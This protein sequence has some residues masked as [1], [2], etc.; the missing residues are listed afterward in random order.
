MS[1]VPQ[2]LS[3]EELLDREM[4]V[5]FDQESLEFALEAI[6]SAFNQSLPAG[7]T[8]PPARIIGGD[9]ELMGITQNQQVRDFSKANLPLRTVLTDL[10]VGANPDKSSSG[11]S[12]PKQSLIWVVAED[13]SVQGGKAIFITT[14]QAAA[15]KQYVVPREFQDKSTPGQ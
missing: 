12:D 13:P 10:V 5:S 7:S 1:E 11:P 9:L 14:R 2:A 4:A 8:L 3:I 6:I 15:T